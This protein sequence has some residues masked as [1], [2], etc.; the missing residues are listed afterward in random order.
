[1]ASH[2]VGCAGRA[3]DWVR[4]GKL[5]GGRQRRRA[6]RVRGETRAGRRQGVRNF[7]ADPAGFAQRLRTR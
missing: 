5:G 4:E 7:C 2:S 3:S 1:M 6:R